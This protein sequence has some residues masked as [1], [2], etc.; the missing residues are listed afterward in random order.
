M[1]TGGINEQR[2]LGQDSLERGEI[3]RAQ[4]DELYGRLPDPRTDP[5]EQLLSSGAAVREHRSGGRAR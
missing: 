3:N 4:F 1:Y 5:F 2:R